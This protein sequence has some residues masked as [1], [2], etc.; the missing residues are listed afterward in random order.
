MRVF[1]LTSIY[2]H[3]PS[4]FTDASPSEKPVASQYVGGMLWSLPFTLANPLVFSVQFPK[5]AKGSCARVVIILK[6]NK[7]TIKKFNLFIA[8]KV[9]NRPDPSNL[10]HATYYLH[11]LYTNNIKHP[12]HTLPGVLWRFAYSRNCNLYG[13]VLKIDP[14]AISARRFILRISTTHSAKSSGCN[15]LSGLPSVN[16]P[17][18]L[19]SVAI[20]L[21]VRVTTRISSFRHS[22]II[23]CESEITAAL[24]AA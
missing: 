18:I 9:G 3:C 15:T 19:I 1:W 11:R 20:V 7:E 4:S 2:P 24:E 13:I 16:P 6:D 23:D 10:L 12:E 21:G 8:V 17:C 14:F 22:A 5:D